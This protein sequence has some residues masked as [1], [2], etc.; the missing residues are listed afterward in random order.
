LAT[1]AAVLGVAT[2]MAT[3]RLCME[4][5][6]RLF[7]HHR[8]HTYHHPRRLLMCIRRRSTLILTTGRIPDV[9]GRLLEADQGTTLWASLSLSSSPEVPLW[10]KSGPPIAA[11]PRA[12]LW[13]KADRPARRRKAMAA[14]DFHHFRRVGWSTRH[15]VDYLGRLAT[16]C[17]RSICR[18]PQRSTGR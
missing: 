15:R 8:R 10:V 18:R 4:F 1:H 3:A 16:A 7:M 14:H 12:A 11:G 9:I 6:R 5:I 13:P 2:Y 17:C